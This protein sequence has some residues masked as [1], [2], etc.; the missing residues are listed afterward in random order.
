MH[1][2]H[3]VT[4][5]SLAPLMAAAFAVTLTVMSRFIWKKDKLHGVSCLALIPAFVGAALGDHGLMELG[6][7]AL[8]IVMAIGLTARIIIGGLRAKAAERDQSRR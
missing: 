7:R 1:P 8:I 6:V 4:Y 5:A 2:D 3:A